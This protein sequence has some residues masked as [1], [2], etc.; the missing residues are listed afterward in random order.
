M[1]NHK[2]GT[3]AMAAVM[4]GMNITPI[5]AL[6]AGM[7]TANGNGLVDVYQETNDDNSGWQD[8]KTKTKTKTDGEY[9]DGKIHL[10]Y[11]TTGGKWQ[12][13]GQDATKA[14]D[15]HDHDNGTYMLTIPTKI[16]YQNMNV[17]K[18]DTSDDYTVNVRGAIAEDK[19][20]TVTAETGKVMGNGAE[21]GITETTTQGKTTWTAEEANGGFNADGSL[22]GTDTTDNIKMSGEA[23][24]AG[25]YE[26]SVAYTATLAKTSDGGYTPIPITPARTADEIAALQ[27]NPTNIASGTWGTC[28]WWISSDGT[29]NIEAGTGA[30]N[31]SVMPWGGHAEQIKAFEGPSGGNKIVMP[32]NSQYMFDGCSGLTSLDLTPLKTDNVTDMRYMFRGCSG[33]TSLD[34]SPLKTDNVTDMRYMFK[35]CSGLTSLDLSPLKTDNVTDMRHMFSGCS[36]L[37]S[38][39]LSSLKTGNVTDMNSMFYNCSSLTSLNLTPLKTDKVTDMGYM[40]GGCSGL[41]SLD[42][43]HLKTDNV[44]NMGGMFNCC[45]GLTSLD[46]SPLKTDNVTDMN[47]MFYNCSGLTSLDLSSLKTDNVMCMGC[48]FDGCSGL[49]SLCTGDDFGIKAVRS[50]DKA[51][52]PKAMTMDGTTAMKSGEQL[53]DG[54]H[55]YTAS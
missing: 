39:D 4:A 20:I 47:T 45:S 16:H 3:V 21:S 13:P 5:I 15:N 34:L 40:F 26:G 54:A 48:M 14:D 25:Q 32:A 49:T 12:D 8:S 17:G 50:Y 31:S 2:L 19:Q 24:T 10:F 11:D 27:A 53:A 9:R 22:K 43:S 6:A 30:N 37:T 51:T 7:P 44:K 41:T 23:K 28:P 33:L 36:G 18:V 35:G 55:T 42:L 29:L 38:L 46:L 52:L 1:L